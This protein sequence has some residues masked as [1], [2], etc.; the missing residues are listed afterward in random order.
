VRR[1]DLDD[2][3]RTRVEGW[4]AVPPSPES[5]DPTLIPLSHKKIF[6]E[7]IEGVIEAD[8]V[9]APEERENLALFKDL[10][11]GKAPVVDDIDLAALL[12]EEDD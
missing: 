11:S 10:L 1:L 8:G 9:I 4:L 5:V 7:A 12:R 6:L 2:D 3:E